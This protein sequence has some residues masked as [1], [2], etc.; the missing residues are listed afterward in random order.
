MQELFRRSF[1]YNRVLENIFEWVLHCVGQAIP[2][3]DDLKKKYFHLVHFHVCS[4]SPLLY[5]GGFIYHVAC[6]DDFSRF[7]ILQVFKMHCHLVTLSIL[8]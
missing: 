3:H 8:F 5:K 2:H 6:L 7:R 1:P 4:L